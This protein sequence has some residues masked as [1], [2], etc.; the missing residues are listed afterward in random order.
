MMHSVLCVCVMVITR[1]ACVRY[2][3]RKR[4]IFLTVKENA[5]ALAVAAAAAVDT[6]TDQNIYYLCASTAKANRKIILRHFQLYTKHIQN[7]TQQQLTQ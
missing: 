1:K 7:T 5:V 6:A 2:I 3:H 4:Y